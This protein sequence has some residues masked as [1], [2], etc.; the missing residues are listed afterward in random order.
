MTPREKFERD[1]T[2]ILHGMCRDRHGAAKAISENLNN[3]AI[4]RWVLVEERLPEFSKS[5]IGRHPE[6]KNA[7]FNPEGTLECF[8]TQDGKTF[9]GAVWNDEQDCYET[10]TIHPLEWL[11]LSL[12]NEKGE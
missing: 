11:D 10:E 1:T 5:V 6:W 12:P 4:G 3:Y 2:V 9:L 7:D 8:V